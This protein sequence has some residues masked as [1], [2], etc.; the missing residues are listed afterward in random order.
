MPPIAQLHEDHQKYSWILHPNSKS[1]E[2]NNNKK[3]KNLFTILLYLYYLLF[4]CRAIC[5]KFSRGKLLNEKRSVTWHEEAMSMLHSFIRY[6]I[7]G[8]SRGI[9]DQFVGS[10][11]KLHEAC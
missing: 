2:L 5:N 3:N 11:E 9:L 1:A 8:E 7:E 10:I 6:I 4:L